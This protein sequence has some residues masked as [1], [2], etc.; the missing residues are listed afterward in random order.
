MDVMSAKDMAFVPSSRMVS[1]PL[2]GAQNKRAIARAF[3]KACHRYDD[4]ASFQRQVGHLLLAQLPQNLKGKR[5]LDVG[6]GTG[7]FTEELLNRGAE[8][9]AL[10]IA[11][12]MLVTC[13]ERSASTLSLISLPWDNLITLP[14]SP[15]LNLIQG[16]AECLPL[17]AHSVDYVF[18]NLAIQWC[19]SLP[20]V[21]MQMKRVLK[22][23][24]QAIFS[25]LV[26]GSLAELKRAWQQVDGGSHV[27]DFLSS[28]ALDAAMLELACDRY[29]VQ[30]FPI[31]LRYDSVVEL[32]KTLK[33]IGANHVHHRAQSN[34]TK[35]KL[36]ALENAYQA[37]DGQQG[38]VLATY[39]VG[40]GSFIK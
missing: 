28:N 3:D 11:F 9:I 4:F 26:E 7:Y 15:R 19:D 1:A 37:H 24:G 23:Q 30:V 40:L 14:Q 21:L 27:N 35:S 10:D 8:V 39:Q 22:P 16:D 5:V 32:M 33:G 12:K 17:Q 20:V 34:V 31:G 36:M 29:Q 13:A 2:G 38:R 25:T 6:C 18:S